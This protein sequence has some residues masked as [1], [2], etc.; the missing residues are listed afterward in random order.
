M[1]NPICLCC[2]D[3]IYPAELVTQGLYDVYHSYC[4]QQLKE[5][6]KEK[7]YEL[8]DELID[9]TDSLVVDNSEKPIKLKYENKIG[10]YIDLT[11]NEKIIDEYNKNY[12]KYNYDKINHY[13]K[14]N[15]ILNGPDYA[16][17]IAGNLVKVDKNYLIKQK[18]SSETNKL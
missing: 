8:T 1:Q 15:D 3:I 12:K 11:T 6:N 18:L 4:Y 17:D 7:K 5:L 9:V 10:T 13:T 14:I 16:T 2:L